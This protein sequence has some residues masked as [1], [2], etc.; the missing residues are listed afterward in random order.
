MLLNLH[1]KNV[2]VISELNIEFSGGF[3]AMTG[4]TGAGKS[5]I[6]D[7]INMVLGARMG[8]DII[9]YGED[10]ALSEAVFAV[11]N[12]ETEKFLAEI[13]HQDEDG[14]VIVSR[15]L[16]TDGKSI[17]RINGRMTTASV[18]RD[19]AKTLVNIHGQ[20]DSQTLLN[21][22]KHIKFLDSFAETDELIKQYKAIYDERKELI[23]EIEKRSLN[24][25]ER[26]QRIDILKFQADEIAAA[27]LE[28][29]DEEEKLEERREFLDKISTITSVVNGTLKRLTE[30]DGC[31]Y[32]RIARISSEFDGISEYSDELAEIARRLNSVTVEIEDIGYTVSSFAD[33]MSYSPDELDKIY[34]R[35]STIHGLE[36]K[37]GIDIK[38]ILEYYAEITAQLNDAVNNDEITDKLKKQLVE[39]ESRLKGAADKLTEARRSA[40]AVLEQ[41]IKEQLAQLDMPGSEFKVD[42]TPCDYTPEGCD[43]TEF[44]ISANVGE[45]PKSLGKIASGG[46][47]SRV[48][49]A[50]KSILSDADDVNTMIFDEIDT[51]VSG[52]AAGKIAEKLR[53]VAKNKQVLCIT[54]LAQLASKADNHYLIEKNVTDGKTATT[55]TLLSGQR[56]IEEIARIMGGS[57]VTQTTLDAARE[58]IE[59]R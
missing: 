24:E 26:L 43:K 56:R 4:E 15:E 7:A 9:R 33:E 58:L 39:T 28:D 30:A 34:S 19:L 17:C 55:V 18:L 11:D 52:R 5:I 51:G 27:E 12:P 21:P 44:L 6:I 35:L 31:V 20:H 1:I 23:S 38:S 16:C 45:I 2:A 10:R 49:L 47:M 29:I 37:Y 59:N 46:E 8:K 25:Q 36:K 32:D 53:A 22:S 13:G 48:M 3:S 57:Q 54:H 40:A 42:I 14:T 50:I 41:K